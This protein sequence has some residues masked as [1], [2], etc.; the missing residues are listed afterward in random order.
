[1]TESK[2]IKQ[3]SF[4]LFARKYVDT[5]KTCFDDIKLSE[6]EELAN[7]LMKIWG[8][9]K[10]LYIC[11]NGGS[12]ANAIHIANDFHYGVGVQKDKN[13]I[14]GIRVEA[15]SA[16]TGIITCLANDL[17]YEYIYS[18]QIKTK[19]MKVMF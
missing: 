8:E 10:C 14:A 12:A 7:T 1:M 6:I 3:G 2:N 5:L 9:N 17:G 18:N 13:D 11:G 4:A 15:L 19:G 16:N